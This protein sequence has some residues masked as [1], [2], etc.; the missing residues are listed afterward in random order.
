M[1]ENR[2]RRPRLPSLEIFGGRSTGKTLGYHQW[3]CGFS[4]LA[5]TESPSDLGA[6]IADKVFRH[7]LSGYPVLVPPSSGKTVLGQDEHD[8]Q[9]QRDARYRCLQARRGFHPVDPDLTQS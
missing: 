8:Q 4:G 9:D 7:F 6:I 3:P 2:V 5:D 1:S